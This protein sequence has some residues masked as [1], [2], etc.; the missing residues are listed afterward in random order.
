M[1]RN[2]SGKYRQPL[3]VDDAAELAGGSEK[4]LDELNSREGNAF[5]IT[6]QGFSE[7]YKSGE[8]MGAAGAISLPFILGYAAYQAAHPEDVRL[9]RLEEISIENHDSGWVFFP[10]GKYSEVQAPY[11]WEPLSSWW[12][13]SLFEPPSEQ[14][15]EAL[16]C[17]WNGSS[18]PLDT[19]GPPAEPPKVSGPG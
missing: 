9:K 13:W 1:A 8:S 11:K 7:F 15:T 12:S 14:K 2:E 16:S 18:T 10:L 5:F 3:L 17:P 6:R 4:L 19:P